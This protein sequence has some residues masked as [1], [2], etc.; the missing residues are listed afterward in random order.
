MT[1][2]VLSVAYQA[3]IANAKLLLLSQF[4]AANTVSMGILIGSPTNLIVGREIDLG[5]VQYFLLMLV[6]SLFAL[7]GTVVVVAWISRLVERMATEQ[8]GVASPSRRRRL[9]RRFAG[10]WTFDATYTTPRFAQ[11][12]SFTGDMKQWIAVFTI[13]VVLLAFGAGSSS[14]LLVA[15]VAMAV[16]G[17]GFLRFHA[18]R[19]GEPTGLPFVVRLLREMPFGIVFFG[20]TYFVV[21]DAVANQPFV[22]R[23]VEEAVAA[24]GST[25]TPLSSWAAIATSGLLV[26]GVNDLPAS[27]LTGE[28]LA[29]VDERGTGAGDGAGFETPF[30]RVLVTQSALVGLN[31]GTYVTPVGALA[32]I[33]WFNILQRERQRRREVAVAAGRQPFDVILPGRGDLVVYGAAT[34]LAV[35]L[36]LGTTNF[37]FVAL[38]D[39]LAGPMSGHT[40]FSGVPGHLVWWWLSLGVA[41]AVVVS[42]FRELRRHRVL[43]THLADLLF[44][45]TK[46]RLLAARHRVITAGAMFATLFALSAALLYHVELF[47][48]ANYDGDGVWGGSKRSEFSGPVDFVFWL[49]VF[50]TSG[51]EGERDG[52]FPD[53]VF[54]RLMTPMLVLGAF[55]SVVFVVRVL[56]TGSSDDHVRRRIAVGDIPSDRVTIVNAVMENRRLV[57]TLA[58]QRRRF[59]TVATSSPRLMRWLGNRRND[60]MAAVDCAEHPQD[61]DL[62]TE[63]RLAEAKEI[64]LLS[65]SVADDFDNVELLATL[66]VLVGGDD[67]A[68]DDPTTADNAE[69]PAILLQQH[70]DEFGDLVGNR[71]SRQLRASIVS[72]ELTD[73]VRSFLVADAAGRLEDLRR[74]YAGLDSG[75]GPDEID[76]HIRTRGLRLSLG[77]RSDDDG[78]AVQSSGSQVVVGVQ[79]MTGDRPD[80]RTFAARRARE[81]HRQV[82]GTVVLEPQNAHPEIFENSARTRVY[83]IGSDSLAQLCARDLA[84]CGVKQ[85]AL[86]IGP[87]DVLHPDV[88]PAGVE[89]RRCHSVEAVAEILATDEACDDEAI[90]AVESFA[91]GA[92]DMER[93]LERLSLQRLQQARSDPE[94][95]TPLYV[96]SRGPDRARR[97][98]KYVVDEIIDATW[99]EA[100]YF[101]VFTTLFLTTLP[102]DETTANWPQDLRLG[103]A[104]RIAH[105]LCHLELVR[106]RD[107]WAHEP[108]AADRTVVGMTGSEAVEEDRRI[109]P[110]RGPLVGVIR[111]QV[112]PG[113]DDGRIVTVHVDIPAGDEAIEAD[114]L[115]V[116]LPCL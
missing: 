98:R 33:I 8:D 114:D 54:S 46:V 58:N 40:G 28:V 103:V 73:V 31:I 62:V 64:V 106:A 82:T 22:Q 15:A 45:V 77:V 72:L 35:G 13:A 111:L 36:L 91:E 66:D 20:M 102:G 25:H 71:I 21:A 85:V 81:V 101:A 50:I 99:V 55:A 14:G 1:P 34:F 4:V 65:R 53:S 48:D 110:A 49:H 37:A 97:M 18:P 39:W 60:R 75:Q 43:L 86:L 41:A 59:V 113:E 74:I 93:L 29:E 67:T 38:A 107:L 105:Q 96:C 90:L 95:I 57:E 79:V 76:R 5:F 24:A 44:L 19:Q 83:V 63:L 2:I 6:P 108:R 115:L 92:F 16:L 23:D 116:C 42:F 100:S 27:A 12:R 84:A 9:V 3:R 11:F 104:H 17:I 68:A 89:V 56:Q 30:D 78:E 51:W 112:E 109:G 26:N 32:G 47:H 61:R 7:M 52:I 70:G 69:L 88:V 94:G 10:S 87:N 80:W